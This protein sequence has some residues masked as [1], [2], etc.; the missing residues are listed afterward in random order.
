MPAEV[1]DKRN[2]APK[3][4]VNH[5]ID[6]LLGV[7]K[8]RPV[9]PSYQ[10]ELP[11]NVG[12]IGLGA[13]LRLHWQT[14]SHP[15]Y[16]FQ[17]I[18]LDQLLNVAPLVRWAKRNRVWFV[19]GILAVLTW[20]VL[21]VV[22]QAQWG[23]FLAMLCGAGVALPILVAFGAIYCLPVA[24]AV[25]SSGMVIAE[26]ERQTWDI[27]LSIPMEWGDLALARLARLLRHINPFEPIALIINLCIAGL[28]FVFAVVRYATPNSQ[29]VETL[30]AWIVV[31]AGPFHFL[32]ERLQ[33]FLLACIIGVIAS[34]IAPSRQVAW[35]LALLGM[36]GWL[37]AR[38]LAIATLITLLPP[39]RANNPIITLLSG[40]SGAFIM[41]LPVWAKFI[42]LIVTTLA[43]DLV[44]R[45]LFRWVRY[46]L[47]ATS[48]VI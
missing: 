16:R 2:D 28:I 4:T 35:V 7:Q 37:L 46:H 26:R 19:V 21:Q 8:R 15:L 13:R 9:A 20:L 36:V 5:A 10:T 33:D 3:H 42:L 38:G 45:R 24:V 31:F 23:P 27:L 12:T 29:G 39:S 32:V 41:T 48:Q 44:I 14:E 47:G 1:N 43:Y 17:V 40:F 34:L 11:A 30:L 18:P 22:F 6:P 25:V